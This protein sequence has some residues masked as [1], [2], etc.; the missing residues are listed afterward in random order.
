MEL[1]L[2]NDNDE[3]TMMIVADAV[4]KHCSE[5]LRFDAS[6]GMMTMIPFLI[7]EDSVILSI[8]KNVLAVGIAKRGTARRTNNNRCDEYERLS[9]STL[10]LSY[11]GGDQ[12]RR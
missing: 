3:D 12:K 6:C 5:R 2:D 1:N 11:H 10:P 8:L 7:Q 9:L 4:N